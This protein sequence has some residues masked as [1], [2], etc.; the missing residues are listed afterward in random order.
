M[1]ETGLCLVGC[2][3]MGERHIRAYALLQD[4]GLSPFRLDAV[5]DGDLDRAGSAAATAERLLG[6][7]PRVFGKLD[8]ALRSDG[9]EA[10][11]VATDPSSHHAVG[12]AILRA[13]RHLICEKPLALTPTDCWDLIDAA[14]DAG[15]VLATAENLR[16]DPRIRAV[17]AIMESGA[18]GR[19]LLIAMEFLGGTDEIVISPW[20][21]LK[22]KG[23]IALDLAVHHTD[24]ISYLGGDFDRA[25]G[26]AFIAHEVRRKRASPELDLESY[27]ARHQAMPPFVVATGDDLLV[28]TYR[29]KSGLIA[30]YALILAGPSRPPTVMVQG[31]DGSIVMPLDA[32][33][34]SLTATIGGRTL[35][36]R[37]IQATVNSVAAAAGSERLHRAAL[38]VDTRDAA[39]IAIELLDFARAMQTGSAPEV[40][41]LQGLVAVA[42]VLAVSRSAR[43]GHAVRIDALVNAGRGGATAAEMNDNET[44]QADPH[45][46]N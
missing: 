14:T 38:A 10:F 25:F 1:T 35:S 13:G 3:G 43:T 41:G 36:V 22:E 39:L 46:R 11:D 24:L 16:R 44:T 18:L 23:S 30:Q 12:M 7:S 17:R 42:A 34:G 40:D 27:R 31:R 5:C 32:S 2:G 33:T 4:L 45:R 28:A 6:R 8:D 9:I 21:H 29:M 37:E 19:I 20:R 15:V 26:G